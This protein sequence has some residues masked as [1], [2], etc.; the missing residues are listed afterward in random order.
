MM[1]RAL[2]PVEL[3]EALKD[4]YLGQSRGF[5]R[6]QQSS[7]FQNGTNCHSFEI[8]IGQAT[9]PNASE[10]P[11]SKHQGGSRHS[12]TEGRAAPLKDCVFSRI[13]TQQQKQQRGK[14]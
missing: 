4:T 8:A 3:L 6:K 7:A 1:P 14:L 11:L 13:F 9:K 2:K 10:C 12:R 5:G